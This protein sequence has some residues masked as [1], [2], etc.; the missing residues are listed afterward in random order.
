MIGIVDLFAV[1]CTVP[2]GPF[3]SIYVSK[4]LFEQLGML[5]ASV[6]PSIV[7]G[8]LHSQPYF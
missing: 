4:F 7:L 6:I 3:D 5:L 1:R 2:I 8:A